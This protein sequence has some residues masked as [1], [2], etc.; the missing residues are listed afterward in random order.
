MVGVSNM[1]FVPQQ[2]VYLKI[3]NGL[4]A[5]PWVTNCG[6]HPK[7]KMESLVAS[8]KIMCEEHRYRQQ[9]IHRYK[10]EID[11]F[12]RGFNPIATKNLGI[13][14]YRFSISMENGNYPL[15]YTEKITDCFALG[16]IPVYWGCKEIGEIFDTNGIIMLTNDFTVN[17]LSV[18][19]YHSKLESIKKNYEI[20]MNLPTVEDYIYITYIK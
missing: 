14:D 11:L 4:K 10:N 8:N 15:M 17:E 3:S 1:K 9:I 6:I 20:T 5:R 13:Q 18:E 12:G 19:L 16:T 7:T 2:E